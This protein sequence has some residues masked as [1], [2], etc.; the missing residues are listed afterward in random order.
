MPDKYGT[1]VATSRDDN[2]EGTWTYDGAEY[3]LLTTAPT[4]KELRQIDA[5]LEG[6]EDEDAVMARVI[7]EY[8]VKPDVDSDNVELPKLGSLFIGMQ[9]AWAERVDLSDLKSE[10]P[11]DQGNR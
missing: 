1:E 11:V 6:T 8:L 10:M 3:K 4:R 7:D 9:K 5:E 2:I